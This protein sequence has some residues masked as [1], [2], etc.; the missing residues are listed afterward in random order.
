[1][2]GS[3]G[4]TGIVGHLAATLQPAV[5]RVTVPTKPRLSRQPAS[6]QEQTPLKMALLVPLIP[7][8]QRA[9]DVEFYCAE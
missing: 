5:P 1:M 3:L 8:K 4:H 7:A 2:P 6:Q 9:L